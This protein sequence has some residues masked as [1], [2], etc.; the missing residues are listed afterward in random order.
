MPARYVICPIVVQSGIRVPKVG[1]IHDPGRVLETDE[2]GNVLSHHVYSFVASDG[3]ATPGQD[4]GL[5]LGLVAGLDMAALNSD[6]EIET[7]VDVPDVLLPEIRAILDQTPNERL[8]G[9]QKNKLQR[10]FTD[11]GIDISDLTFD[12]PFW[13]W[14]S[15]LCEFITGAPADIRQLNTTLASEG[16]G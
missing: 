15:R 13:I 12:D 7:L 4:D 11:R 2:S 9:G 16:S 14:A 1:T 10:V 6:P 5:S 8:N 3:N